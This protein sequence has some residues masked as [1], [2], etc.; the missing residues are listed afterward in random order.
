[1]TRLNTKRRLLRLPDVLDAVG[2]SKASIYSK[3]SA[4][5][6]PLPVKL[7]ARAVAWPAEAVDQWIATRPS[8]GAGD[9]SRRHR[10]RRNRPAGGA[11]EAR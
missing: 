8:T 7:G 2:L 5:D 9:G 6:F 10:P 3:I 1:M 11:G 4:G